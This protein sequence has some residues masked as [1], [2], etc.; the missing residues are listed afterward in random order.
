MKSKMFSFLSFIE[1]PR[2]I[3]AVMT[4]NEAPEQPNEDP[5]YERY[6]SGEQ[7]GKF[8]F[9]FQFAAILLSN[10]VSRVQNVLQPFIIALPLVM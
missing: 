2:V 9:P 8:N 1:I 3:S 4:Q 7:R 5:T 10:Y 6:Q